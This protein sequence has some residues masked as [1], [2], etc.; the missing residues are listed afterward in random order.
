[1]A[2]DEVEAAKRKKRLSQALGKGGYALL[3][4]GS[5]LSVKDL[6][7]FDHPAFGEHATAVFD[8]FVHLQP[9]VTPAL[10]P[11]VTVTA[12]GNEVI[13]R[14]NWRID[15]FAL[16]QSRHLGEPR[17]TG[18]GKSESG[19]IDHALLTRVEADIVD[20]TREST[21]GDILLLGSTDP[22]P[23]TPPKSNADLAD[24]RAQSVKSLMD[25][26]LHPPRTPET[27]RQVMVLNKAMSLDGEGG[28]GVA[29]VLFGAE[30]TSGRSVVACVSQPKEPQATV[31]EGSSS[32][33]ELGSESMATLILGLFL[34]AFATLTAALALF[35]MFRAM[36]KDRPLKS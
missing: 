26:D 21:G 8:S 14:P 24:E 19:D 33:S 30:E 13:C 12:G 18:G 3:S 32:A 23:E 11:T 20:I 9:G 29:R 15:G 27:H 36:H 17:V 31:H 6:H 34:G 35:L 16:G 7:L 22:T 28:K 2:S 4:I 10:R 1:M 5:L 25:S